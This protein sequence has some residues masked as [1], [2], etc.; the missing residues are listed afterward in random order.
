MNKY[1]ESVHGKAILE[2]N[3]E[4]A[5]SCVDCHGNHKVRRVKDPASKVARINDV[6]TC[7]SEKCHGSDELARKPRMV[8]A[9][10]GYKET[11]H[12]KAL[13][14]GVKYVAT[15]T[16]CHGGHGIYENKDPRSTVHKDNRYKICAEKCH[17]SS[18]KMVGYG[19]MHA[20]PNILTYLINA[21]YGIV[22]VVVV[23]GLGLF[24]VLDFLRGLTKRREKKVKESKE[25]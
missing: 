24:I 12:G 1:A 16:T 21:F 22:I 4:D 20:E 25:E 14:L 8:N 10:K 6:D 2:E 5:A 23:G 19:S 9:L 15:C 3:A 11:F 7:G 17:E 13:A 18:A